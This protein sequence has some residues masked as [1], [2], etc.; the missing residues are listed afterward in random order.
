MPEPLH[1]CG[2]RPCDGKKEELKPVYVEFGFSL[3]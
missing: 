1:L 3:K 2:G